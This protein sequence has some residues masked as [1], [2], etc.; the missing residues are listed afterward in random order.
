MKV[1]HVVMGND[2]PAAVFDTMEA[3]EAYCV[4]RRTM[5]PFNPSGSPR[6]HWRVYEFKLNDGLE[7]CQAITERNA[8]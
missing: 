4:K 3:A 6:I 5:G 8:Q 1:V 2:Y 7:G